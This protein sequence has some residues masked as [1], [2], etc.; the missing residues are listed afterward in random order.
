M[1]IALCSSQVAGTPNA[2]IG[3]AKRGQTPF[4]KARAKMP[5]EA[6]N[7][8]E[9]HIMGGRLSFVHQRMA[10]NGMQQLL[11]HDSTAG[12]VMNG[13]NGSTR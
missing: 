6:A 9:A 3:V 8:E 12:S 11:R 10:G 1:E 13:P 5:G 4:R 2:A 7:G